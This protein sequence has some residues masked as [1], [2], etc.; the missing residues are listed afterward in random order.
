MQPLGADPFGECQD[1][2]FVGF[3]SNKDVLQNRHVFLM[4][5]RRESSVDLTLPSHINEFKVEPHLVLGVTINPGSEAVMQFGA[6]NSDRSIILGYNAESASAD[7]CV[8]FPVQAN[9]REV[10][11]YRAVSFRRSYNPVQTH[12]NSTVLVIG[13]EDGTRIDVTTTQHAVGRV[14][15]NSRARHTYIFSNGDVSSVTINKYESLTL[16][17]LKDL[18]G[19]AIKASHPVAV[20][21][22]HECASVPSYSSSCDHLVEQI[23]PVN[24]LGTCYIAA[25]FA[26][27]ESG[28]YVRAVAVNSETYIK[29]RCTENGAVVHS[30]QVGPYSDGEFYEFYLAMDW[31]CTFES[32]EPTMVVQFSGANQGEMYGDPFMVVH[33]DVQRLMN[34]IPFYSIDIGRGNYTHYINVVVPKE[35]F[36]TSAILLDEDPLSRYEYLTEEV[37]FDKCGSFVVVRLAVTP[38]YHFLHHS[39]PEAGLGLT[40]YGFAADTSYGYSPGFN[41]G[42]IIIL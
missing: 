4:S 26:G 19:T 21:S 7:A 3:L 39:S 40:V 14:H 5:G 42:E 18:T 25:A 16:S 12:Y 2:Y 17:S 13:T 20:Y 34:E 23:P 38:G 11:E 30:D 22:G 32:N 28:D 37:K 27:R 41:Q 31:H 24:V 29:V 33:S 10:E 35:F 9:Y 8:S 6:Y 15:L 1:S 36:N